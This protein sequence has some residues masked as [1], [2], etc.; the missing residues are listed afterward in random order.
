M[1]KITNF[2]KSCTIIFMLLI[3][4]YL[5]ISSFFLNADMPLDGV[6]EKTVFQ[7][8]LWPF[9]IL[10]TLL[11]LYAL[12]KY[13]TT[14]AA[15]DTQKLVWFLII[16]DFVLCML[17]IVLSNTKEGADQAQVL[18]SAKQFATGNYER[19]AYNQYMG[20]FPYQLPL[21]LLYEP[22]YLL[23]GDVT[24]FLW[25]FINAFLIC[26]IQYLLYL[27]VRNYLNLKEH[28]NLYLLLQLGNLPLILYTS[29]IYGTIIG[30]FLALAAIYLLFQYAAQHKWKHLLLS[31]LFIA[32]S[33]LLR[34]NNIIVMIALIIFSILLA[35]GNKRI[36]L[37]IPLSI[38]LFSCGKQSV[39]RFYEARSGISIC[40]G[41]PFT[42]NIAMGLSDN[43]E[44]AAGWYNGYT[45]DT[46][47]DLGCDT[48]AA[49]TFAMERIHESL[50][51]FRSSISY[52]CDFFQEKINSTWLNPD[53]QGLWNNEHHGHYVARAPIINNLFAG[54]LH[55][56]SVFLLGNFQFLIYFEAFLFPLGSWKKL[57]WKHLS[58]AVIFIGGFLFHL[59]WEAKA[60]YVI[61]YYILL[62]PYS[63]VGLSWLSGIIFRKK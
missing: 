36:L 48:A 50:Q 33:C 11:V 17:W 7:K 52:T 18:Y 44:R 10:L 5:S 32:C 6:S 14:I 20:L 12:H 9:T 63:A 26:T 42:M 56:L 41:E 13:Q 39:Y 45:W 24:P 27:I 3:T 57:D 30:L 21:S 28:I 31:S 35:Y 54:E 62:F 25:Q 15:M 53:F 19:L 61:V 22:F 47:Y 8:T 51:K 60:Q 59:F 58:F 29:F 4:G 38:L 16:Y 40:N 34:T 49:S 2:Y 37:L 43:S 55:T 46:Y 23:F 1:K